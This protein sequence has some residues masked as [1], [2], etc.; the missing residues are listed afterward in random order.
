MIARVWRGI[1]PI[2]QADAYLQHLQE[3]A[4]PVL[5]TQPGLESAWTLR[6]EQGDKC[7]FQLVTVWD[8]IDSMR[9]WAGGDAERS[10]YFD[11]DERYLLGMEPLVRLYDVADRLIPDASG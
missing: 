2:E 1:T 5:R 8:S 10:V 7:E 9:A 4:M 6:R 11:E 3:T